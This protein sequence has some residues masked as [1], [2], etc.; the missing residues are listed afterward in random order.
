MASMVALS[1]VRRATWGAAREALDG[2]VYYSNAADLTVNTESLVQNASTKCGLLAGSDREFRG[3]TEHFDTD[4]TGNV[5]RGS[6]MNGARVSVKKH[7][8]AR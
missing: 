5:S 1:Q 8:E 4:E 6:A 3:S 2:R 7:D